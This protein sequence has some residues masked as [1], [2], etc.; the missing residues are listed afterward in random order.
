VFCFKCDTMDKAQKPG[1]SCPIQ[2]SGSLVLNTTYY[3][4]YYYL[5]AVIKYLFINSC[6]I[7]PTLMNRHRIRHITLFRRW[8]QWPRGLTRWSAL[9]ACWDCGFESS[10]GHRYLSVVSVCSLS[11]GG[12][13][14]ALVTRRKESYRMWCV[15]VWSWSLDNEEVLI[16]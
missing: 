6:Y 3:Y 10:R 8:Y 7:T 14:V 1:N 5:V 4:Y 2:L 13:C 11:G 15:W 12:V 16:H 9:R